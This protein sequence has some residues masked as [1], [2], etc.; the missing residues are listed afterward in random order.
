M[1]SWWLIV[2]SERIYFYLNNNTSL[3]DGMILFCAVV[4]N[5]GFTAAARKLGHTPSHVSKEIA[6]LE[7][8]LGV[9]L[10]N[11]TTRTVSLTDVGSRY[12][13]KACHIIEDARQAEDQILSVASTPSGLLKISIPVSFGLSCLNAWLPE[14]LSLYPD[15]RLSID[16]SD[17]IVDIVAEGFD[18]VVRAGQLGDSDLVA[19][20]L[21]MS[22][23]L[24]VASPDYLEK[25]GIPKAP[26]DLANHALIDFS[27]RQLANTWRFSGHDGE[28]IS[29]PVSARVTCNS[30]ETEEVLA[31]DGIGITRLPSFVCQKAIDSSALV[32]ILEPFENPPIGIYAIYPSRLQLAPKV[33]VFVDFLNEK[34]KE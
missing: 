3:F 4:E 7:Q 8:R 11:R 21:M 25:A 29:I 30:G 13:E 17:R 24:I 6:R 12:F 1:L 2:H 14:F 26:E 34:S 18:V 27:H 31:I 9:R 16:A 22:R 19:K 33:R 5:D 20:R 10:L 32:S 28:N 23:L 15:I